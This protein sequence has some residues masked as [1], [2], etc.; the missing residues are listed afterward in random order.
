MRI[1]IAIKMKTMSMMAFIYIT[2]ELGLVGMDSSKQRV[3]AGR[4]GGKT[5]A[6]YHSADSL[7]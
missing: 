6:A 5:A 2:N 3:S 1:T 4:S 7:E